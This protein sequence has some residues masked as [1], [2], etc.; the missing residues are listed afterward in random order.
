MLDRVKLGTLKQATARED[1]IMAAD[2]C[3]ELALESV[4]SPD[5]SSAPELTLA[6]RLNDSERLALLIDEM[7]S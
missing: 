4:G 5:E 1:W 7:M 3:L 2:I 6:V